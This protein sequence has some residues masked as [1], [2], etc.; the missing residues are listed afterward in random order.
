MRDK[1]VNVAIFGSGLAGLT[2]AVT[3][4]EKGVTG[5]AIFEK[6]ALSGR[7]GVQYAHVCDGGKK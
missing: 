5:V 7:R 1:T 2:A 3:L 4:L 6:K